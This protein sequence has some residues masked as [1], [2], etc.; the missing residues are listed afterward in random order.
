MFSSPSM[1]SCRPAGSA[2]S[3]ASWRPGFRGSMWRPA[4]DIGFGHFAAE[5][6]IHPIR[7]IGPPR[8]LILQPCFSSGPA[9]VHGDVTLHLTHVCVPGCQLQPL[10]HLHSKTLTGLPHPR[11]NRS[12]TTLRQLC[13]NA[14]RAGG[15]VWPV[16]AQSALTATGGKQM[17]R[18]WE[19]RDRFSRGYRGREDYS[20]RGG[21]RDWSDRAG[22][23]VRSWFG[24]DDAD[25]RRR[26]DDD[27]DYGMSDRRRY[28][29]Q[30]DDYGS[31]GGSYGGSGS[32]SG[33]GGYGDDYGR[34]SDYGSRSGDYGGSSGGGYGGRSAGG[35]G[36]DPYGS[37]RG[38]FDQGRGG[39]YGR[40]GYSET[41]RSGMASR[42]MGMANYSSGT[43]GNYG[44]SGY[45]E[46]GT[47]GTGYGGQGYSGRDYREGSYRGGSD[48]RGFFERAGDEVASWF[49]NE[50]AQRRRERDA[51]HSGRGPKNY[52]RSDDRIREDVS[53]RLSDDRHIDASDI[54]V[55][56]SGSEVT[57]TGTVESRFAKRHA[58]DLAESCSGVRHVQNNLRVKDGG[59]STGVSGSSGTGSTGVG[60]GGGITGGNSTGSTGASSIG[61]GSTSG[62]SETTGGG[63]SKTG[64]SQT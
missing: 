31:R 1:S 22:D 38:D 7:R 44:G 56:V 18:D 37:G 62:S 27:R 30:D 8:N 47:G 4:E 3:E 6:P 36:Y 51:G 17:T 52:S 19:D 57:L 53:D 10:S 42:G 64:S 45:G 21:S 28:G 26:M 20:R 2:P 39:G 35:S 9:S 32:R 40:G 24:D 23:E 34:S 29:G 60:S 50:D 25:R 54:E 15:L 46:R 33:R 16:D 55:S 43:G 14:G 58:E 49:G 41:I 61:A 13:G 48:D 59:A 63:N 12:W 11:W 5:V